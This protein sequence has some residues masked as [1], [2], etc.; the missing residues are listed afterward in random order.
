VQN[1]RESTWLV[2]LIFYRRHICDYGTLYGNGYYW[3]YRSKA[4]LLRPNIWFITPSTCQTAN[5]Q[6]SWK[7]FLPGVPGNSLSWNIGPR[8]D[9]MHLSNVRD[10]FR[11]TRFKSPEER[12]CTSRDEIARIMSASSGGCLNR[13]TSNFSTMIKSRFFACRPHECTFPGTLYT[14][15]RLAVYEK[16]K[17]SGLLF[18]L[19]LLA[20]PSPVAR[21]IT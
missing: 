9:P 8:S 16:E 5:L 3:F 18:A 6:D 4:Q 13:A 11:Y 14:H 2:K 20:I 21:L 10:T 17:P 19:S 12:R 1:L 15:A 7:Q